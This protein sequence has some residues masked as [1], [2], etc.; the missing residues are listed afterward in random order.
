MDAITSGHAVVELSRCA[1]PD[2]APMGFDAPAAFPMRVRVVKRIVDV[3]GSTC[4]LVFGAPLYLLI[5]VMVRLTSPGPVFYHQERVVRV[6]DGKEVTFYMHKFRTMITDAETASGPVWSGD[7]DPR[8]TRIGRILRK[9]RMDELPQFWNVLKGQMSIVGPR[10]ERPHFTAQLQDQ[11]PV[12]YDRS[13]AL[14]PGITGWAQVRCPYDSSLDSV[15]TK[16]LYDLA[17]AA[18]CYRLRSYAKME[19]KVLV[20]TVVVVLTGKGAH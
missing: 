13:I 17:Y 1:E 8:T 12:Y 7:P 18:H 15:K 4:A 9:S 6:V 2:D 20:L 5:A 16:L 11:I 10:P 14:K 3:I 19:L